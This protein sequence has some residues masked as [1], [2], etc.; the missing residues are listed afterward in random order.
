MLDFSFDLFPNSLP[1]NVAYKAC[2]MNP[3]EYTEFT[4]NPLQLSEQWLSVVANLIS[5]QSL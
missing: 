3:P 1:K 2:K 5:T 4:S